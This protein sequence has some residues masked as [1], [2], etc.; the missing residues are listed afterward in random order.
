MKYHWTDG[1][2]FR[3]S[4]FLQPKLHLACALRGAH[5]GFYIVGMFQTI[6]FF[7]LEK[8]GR[9]PETGTVDGTE[10]ES[11]IKRHLERPAPGD[12]VQRLSDARGNNPSCGWSPVGIEDAVQNAL[13]KALKGLRKSSLIRGPKDPWACEGSRIDHWQVTIEVGFTLDE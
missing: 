8:V 3:M 1:S 10:G 6:F 9:L 7:C 4:K 13:F 11:E 5:I 2:E 12:E